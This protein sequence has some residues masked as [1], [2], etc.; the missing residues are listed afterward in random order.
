MLYNKIA[1]LLR[2]TTLGGRLKSQSLRENGE[3]PR[4]KKSIIVLR[5]KRV[6]SQFLEENL[7]GV[8]LQYRLFKTQALELDFFSTPIKSSRL[9]LDYT[10]Y[11][12][13]LTFRH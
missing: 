12:H 4:I 10:T 9:F 1:L 8:T 5:K 2:T 3:L 13:K 7:S 6:S 11:L